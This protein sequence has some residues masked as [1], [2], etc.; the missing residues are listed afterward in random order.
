MKISN[1]V[2]LIAGNL[3]ANLILIISLILISIPGLIYFKNRKLT[4]NPL[5]V[6]N[7]ISFNIDLCHLNGLYRE[8]LSKNR[9]IITTYGLVIDITRLISSGYI[10]VEINENASTAYEK[11]T[12]KI[13][14]SKT[15]KLSSSDKSIINILKLFDNS[16]IN[17]KSMD[18]KL[19]NKSTMK[20]FIN[21]YRDWFLKVERKNT[22]KS[23]YITKY[24]NSFVFL[25]IV[26]IIYL[27]LT[28]IILVNDNAPFTYILIQFS[29]LLTYIFY[30]F[31]F[32]NI[33][34]QYTPEGKEFLNV[35]NSLKNYLTSHPTIEK[36]PPRDWNRFLLYSVCFDVHYEFLDHMNQLRTYKKED[37]QV[38]I[39]ND[40]I[41]ILKDIF[42]KSKINEYTF[43][44]DENKGNDDVDVSEL[45]PPVYYTDVMLLF[46]IFK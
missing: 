38:F 42:K 21:S 13:N 10:S 44:K 24:R 14:N 29:T 8:K 32:D 4:N 9:G 34:G 20:K 23:Y 25:T 1:M 3:I 17:L 46:S 39:E 31:K 2:D 11:I 19:N 41:Q 27:T 45:I 33:F 18:D 7:N 37:V 40:G 22:S 6:P 30:N 26:L 35:L 16:K 15:K 28:I 43:R 12:L 36:Y 5:I